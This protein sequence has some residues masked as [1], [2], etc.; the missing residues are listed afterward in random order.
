MIGSTDRAISDWV[1]KFSGPMTSHLKVIDPRRITK[2]FTGQTSYRMTTKSTK[3]SILY[4]Q[5]IGQT[6][7]R[8]FIISGVALKI[9]C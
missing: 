8:L 7:G 4:R 5:T 2:F 6:T 1:T 9:L 3:D